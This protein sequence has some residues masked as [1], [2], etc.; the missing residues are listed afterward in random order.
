[1][2]AMYSL[3]QLVN[4]PMCVTQKSSSNINHI[5]ASIPE[6][7]CETQV[8]HFAISDHF[9]VCFTHKVATTTFKGNHITM[10][11]R[12]Y[13]HFNEEQ[14]RNNLS[15]SSFDDIFQHEHPE[16]CLNMFYDNF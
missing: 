9:P 6:N 10:E 16:F 15:C 7:L 3:T 14:F 4:V 11:Y 5:Y 2:V 12:S 8:P 1:M 13:K